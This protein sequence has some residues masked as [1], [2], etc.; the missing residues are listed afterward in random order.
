ML[1][2]VRKKAAWLFKLVNFIEVESERPVIS[3]LSLLRDAVSK[4]L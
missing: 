3:A 2:N 4:H 1:A